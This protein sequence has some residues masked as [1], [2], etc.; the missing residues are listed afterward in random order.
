[1][2]LSLGQV[3]TCAWRDIQLRP[4]LVVAVAGRWLGSCQQ[5]APAVVGRDEPQVLLLRSAC[6][7]GPLLRRRNAG[8]PLVVCRVV[9]VC[10]RPWGRVFVCQT[11]GG[12]RG[13]G[14]TRARQRP[15][16]IINERAKACQAAAKTLTLHH[17]HAHQMSRAPVALDETPGARNVNGVPG[18][19]EPTALESDARLVAGG[20]AV[21]L[22]HNAMEA[23]VAVVGALAFVCV[24]SFGR[25]LV[26]VRVCIWIWAPVVSARRSGR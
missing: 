24:C 26:R 17:G 13:R 6:I 14:D 2:I 25:D 8:S 3:D 9:F 10:A 22:D 4:L 20:L 1:M 12:G 18:I 15:L 5:A 21:A 19:P 16:E 23:G 11:S 7:I